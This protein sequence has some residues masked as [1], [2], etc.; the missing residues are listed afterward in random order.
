MASKWTISSYGNWANW[1]DGDA[2][3]TTDL[4]DLG[5]VDFK[6]KFCNRAADEAHIQFERRGRITDESAIWDR[7]GL[8]FLYR[9]SYDGIPVFSGRLEKV[10]PVGGGKS[11]KTE[12]V[13]LGGWHF[14]ELVMCQAPHTYANVSMVTSRASIGHNVAN[15]DI[16][17]IVYWAC[18]ASGTGLHYPGDSYS[19]F[20]TV[21]NTYKVPASEFV[22]CTCAEALN[23]VLAFFPAAFAWTEFHS[24]HNSNI[25]I[26]HVGLRGETPTATIAGGSNDLFDAPNLESYRITQP[27][28]ERIPGVRVIM[29]HEDGSR[30]DKYETHDPDSIGGVIC[31]VDASASA[32]ISGFGNQQ[33]FATF[34]YAENHFGYHE[35][36]LVLVGREPPNLLTMRPDRF[37][38]VVVGGTS[39]PTPIQHVE[40]DIG[41]G[42]TTIG[43]GPPS[44]LGSNDLVSLALANSSRRH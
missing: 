3:P 19:G 33:N 11:Q 21:S 34:L 37:L 25:P 29:E 10:V 23:K 28:A 27:P 40:F 2:I 26:L 14:L 5:V 18:C 8:G 42:R 44:H 43:F 17:N 4:I 7:F 41:R 38:S 35:G 15:T 6:I 12:L 24:N 1:H 31:T 16:V 13:F 36:A 32:S 30:P 20:V 39:W 22:D 9:L